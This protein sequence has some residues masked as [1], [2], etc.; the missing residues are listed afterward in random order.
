MV[1]LIIVVIVI[2]LLSVR[3]GLTLSSL[4]CPGQYIAL[5]AVLIRRVGLSE[6][7]QTEGEVVSSSGRPTILRLGE[8]TQWLGTTSETGVTLTL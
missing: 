3:L 4:S 6:C 2:P 7:D 1:T 5:E 8:V